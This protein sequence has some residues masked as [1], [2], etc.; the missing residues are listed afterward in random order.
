L[1]AKSLSGPYPSPH[2]HPRNTADCNRT[3]DAF[4][5]S[6]NSFEE[7]GKTKEEHNIGS[8]IQI[9]NLTKSFGGVVALQ[10]LSLEIEKGQLLGVLGPNGAGKTTL[11]DLLCG[12]LV[13]DEGNIVFNSMILNK[14][15]PHERARLGISRTFQVCRIF[16]KMSVLENLLTSSSNVKL[17][18]ELLRKFEIEHLANEY[19]ENLSGGQQKLLELARAVIR[20]PKLLIA[21]EPTAGLSP[22]MID[23]V[24][25][26]MIELNRG[27]LTFVIVEH[28]MAVITKCCDSC[29]FLNE[30]VKIV[31]G[32]TCNVVFDPRTV[33][34]YLGR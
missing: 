1:G 26:M 25:E 16:K 32:K 22:A 19:A 15:R 7:I 33:E 6:W 31:H 2:S 14:L 4:W 27:G 3:P 28:N 21:D 13:P 17:A 8:F 29:V 11:L 9:S 20:K 5:D 12:Y 23:I 34:A 18:W 10:D 24:L 30:G